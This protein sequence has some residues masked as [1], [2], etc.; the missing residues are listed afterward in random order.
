MGQNP[1]E[2][3]IAEITRG[4]EGDAVDF[5]GFCE[6]LSGKFVS[7]TEAEAEI[8]ESFKIFDKNGSGLISAAELRHV[9]MNLGE[10]LT[11]EEVE[12]LIGQVELD[13]QGLLNYD[14]FISQLLK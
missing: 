14:D 6:M 10:S 9:M 5:E 1:T 7:N 11:A 4:V 8:R 12:E 2:A 13:D 3:E